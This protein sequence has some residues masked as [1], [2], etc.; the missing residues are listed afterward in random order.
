MIV[1]DHVAHLQLLESILKKLGFR[2]L[3]AERPHDALELLK[4]HKPS[5]V[6]LDVNLP[7][8]APSTSL[9]ARKASHA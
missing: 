5:L 7:D 3:S 9:A 6:V 1:D 8:I 4:E 2:T